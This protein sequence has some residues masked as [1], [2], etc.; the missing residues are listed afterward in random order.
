[1]YRCMTSSSSRPA[2]CWC[3][4]TTVS[5][6][7]ALPKPAPSCNSSWRP[8]PTTSSSAKAPK[9]PLP[10]ARPPSAMLRPRRPKPRLTSAATR[11][12][13][14]MDRCRAATW[15]W[16]VPAR[17]LPSPAWPRPGRRWKSP[18]RTV[19][20]WWST[21]P[22]SRPR[23]RTPRPPW[24]WHASTSTTPASRPRAMASWGRSAPAWVLMSTPA[25]S[26][27]R[28]CPTPFG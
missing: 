23:W 12:W 2:T 5:T 24:S 3:N 25:R 18:A 8:W 9:R 15:T 21:G 19:R 27:W 7:N 17:P 14:T 20:P 26:S 16:P 6:N 28:W 13:S 11:R 22:H 4:W 10:S 1:M